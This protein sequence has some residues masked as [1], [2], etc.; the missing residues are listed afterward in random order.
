MN[1][2]SIELPSA[3]RGIGPCSILIGM[4][5]SGVIRDAFRK[6]GYDAWSCDLRATT[7]DPA[8]H[9]TGN[10]FDII[11]LGWAMA[12][13]HPDCTYLAN[14][15][16]HWNAR[17][18]GRH[19]CTLYALNTVRRLMAG[20]I[21]MWAIEN[22]R[23]AIGTNI[24]PKD[25]RLQPHDFGD[26]ASK[27]THLWLKGLPKLRPT[28]RH[29]GR[30]VAADPL[31]LFGG[32]TERWS[33]QADDGQNRLGETRDRWIKRS[34]T[35]PGVA[36]AMSDQWGAWLESRFGSMALTSTGFDLVNAYNTQI[37]TAPV[38]TRGAEA[39][40]DAL[41]GELTPSGRRMAPIE[42]PKSLPLTTE[43][44]ASIP[45]ALTPLN[46]GTEKNG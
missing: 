5:A 29:S 27:E 2:S 44:F 39:A 28:G 18:H 13:F 45:N 42:Y 14:S 24:R 26:D 34:E 7:A 46:F 38:P 41:S 8:Y 23:G 36:D 35:F 22:P 20:P 21:P 37:E 1:S 11:A 3:W 16:I 4:E 19:A 12:V 17:V 31:D 15:G 33:N 9:F 25:Q 6:R 10:V 43:N 30:I 40:A 32:G